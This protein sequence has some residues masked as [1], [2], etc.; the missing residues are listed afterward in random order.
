[1]ALGLNVLDFEIGIF[2][3]CYLGYILPLFPGKALVSSVSP[4]VSLFLLIL[5]TLIPTLIPFLYYIRPIQGLDYTYTRSIYLTT[6]VLDQLTILF[7]SDPS[8]FFLNI[9][10]YLTLP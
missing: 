7:F 1:M 5:S 6:Q 4:L 10:V 8:L 3:T 9:S 2:A